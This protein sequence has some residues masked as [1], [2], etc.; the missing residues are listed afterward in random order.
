MPLLVEGQ[1]LEDIH[2]DPS[3]EQPPVIRL[4]LW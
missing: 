3:I 1:V 2:G 4:P